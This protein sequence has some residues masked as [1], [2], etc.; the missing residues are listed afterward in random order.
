MLEVLAGTPDAGVSE[1]ARELQISKASVDRLLTTLG[2]AGFVEQDPH[3]RRYSLSLKIAVLGEAVRSRNGIVELARPRLRELS[4]QVNEGVNLGVFMDGAL[5]YA[6]IIPSTRIFRI[7]ARPGT[8]LPAY[9]T[10]AG[11]TLLAFMAPEDLDAYLAALVPT[12]HT[13]TTLTTTASIREE[14][15]QIRR[16]GYAVDRGEML[17]EAWCV[18]A[19]VLGRN[20]LALAAVSI[21]APR[22]QFEA[23]KDELIAAV[24]SAAREIGDRVT[25]VPV[26]P[27]TRRAVSSSPLT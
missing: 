8:A 6:D 15:A 3:T 23:K 10:G 1:L 27:E 22:S 14:L 2:S 5:V 18:A 7:E 4:E 13:P 17:E 19:P 9:C 11:K 24:T 12:Q 20:G 16:S 26:P 25:L 21:T